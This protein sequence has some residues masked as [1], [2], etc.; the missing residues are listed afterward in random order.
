[1]IQQIPQELKRPFQKYIE[2]LLSAHGLLEKFYESEDFYVQLRNGNAQDPLSIE[3]HGNMMAIGQ[4]YKHGMTGELMCDSDVQFELP[5]WLPVNMTGALGNYTEI[6]V[7]GENGE[8]THVRP[9]A[10]KEVEGYCNG[11]W[12]KSLRGTKWIQNS[13]V[14]NLRIEGEDLWEEGKMVVGKVEPA[15]PVPLAPLQPR[16][17]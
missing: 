10:K 1:M 14:W 15:I 9:R 17:I 7:Y 5:M 11:M 3:H 2:S 12:M 6:Y 13:T 16:L 8:K 4:Y